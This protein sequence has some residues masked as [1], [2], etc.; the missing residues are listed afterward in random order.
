MPSPSLC[1]WIYGL[2]VFTE[3]AGAITTDGTKILRIERHEKAQFSVLKFQ[4]IHAFCKPEIP[5]QI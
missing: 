1:V 2:F 3:D 4:N 5:W